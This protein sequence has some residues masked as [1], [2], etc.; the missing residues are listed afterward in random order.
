MTQTRSP[1]T[2]AGVLPQ[3]RV[4]R[5]HQVGI[6]RSGTAQAETR[7]STDRGRAWPG[8]VLVTRWSRLAL[9]DHAVCTVASCRVVLAAAAAEELRS[10]AEPG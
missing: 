6:L 8:T 9:H 1:M 3:D 4:W 10:M 5:R 2:V 7:Q